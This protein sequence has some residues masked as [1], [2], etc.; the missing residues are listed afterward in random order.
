VALD[1]EDPQPV[2]QRI[3]SRQQPVGYPFPYLREMTVRIVLARIDEKPPVSANVDKS[4]PAL[5]DGHSGDDRIRHEHD[6]CHSLIVA[7]RPT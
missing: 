7:D 6:V 1:E 4:F 3:L 5:P 2:R